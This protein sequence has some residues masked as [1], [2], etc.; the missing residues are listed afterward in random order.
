MGRGTTIILL[1]IIMVV[2]LITGGIIMFMKG[3]IQ[4][5]PYSA[6]IVEIYESKSYP[7]DTINNIDVK[8]VSS[9]INIIPVK[10]DDINISFLGSIT[11]K[12]IPKLIASRVGDKLMIE[13]KHP[14]VFFNFG[15]FQE[16]KLDIEI[17]EGYNDK[18]KI[19]TV[20]GD[21]S[22]RRLD[23][24]RLYMDVVSGDIL[25]ESLTS[26]SI[27]IDS[28]SGD[29][30]LDAFSG[31]LSANTVSGDVAVSYPESDD[32]IDIETVSGDIS[33][34]MLKDSGFML[35]FE[36]ISGEVDNQFSIEVER[37]GRNGL[38]GKVGDGRYG[39]NVNTI[40]GDLDITY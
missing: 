10:S 14:V 34:K 25:A 1:L 13:I 7:T 16:T 21:I 32:D 22:L 39:V 27:V 29:I 36:T 18:L 33:M 19:G 30:K 37:S 17:P 3:D 5:G 6:E 9:D 4:L 40:S 8:A 38:H 31:E 24:D 26:K 2:S 28:T 20:S 12:K 23:L 15:G 35:D 11:H